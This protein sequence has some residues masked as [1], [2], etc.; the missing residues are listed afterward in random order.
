ME[1][2]RVEPLYLRDSLPPEI[3]ANGFIKFNIIRSIKFPELVYD[4]RIDLYMSSPF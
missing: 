4:F 2:A 1:D 3:L